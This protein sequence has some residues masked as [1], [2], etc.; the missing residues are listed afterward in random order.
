MKS[1]GTQQADCP[2]NDEPA[3]GALL[4]VAQAVARAVAIARPIG[5][6]EMVGIS[7]ARGRILARTLHAARAMPFFDNSAMDGFAVRIADFSG[8]LPLVL[9]VDGECAAG[10]GHCW[11]L[12]PGTCRRVYTGAR[13]PDGADTIIPIEHVHDMKD[14]VLFSSTPVA[15]AH[16]RRKRLRPR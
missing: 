7:A 4:D 5:R 13:V 16:I 14:K 3:N 1:L 11:P 2:C 12:K 8:N 9:P 6:T 15:S 10:A